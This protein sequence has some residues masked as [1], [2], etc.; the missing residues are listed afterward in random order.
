[1]RPLRKQA[2]SSSE[3]A[4]LESISSTINKYQ[5]IVNGDRVLVGL[6]GGPDSVALLT[7]LQALS[8]NMRFSLSAVYINHQ[9][10]PK[11]HLAEEKFCRNL[12][13]KL[14]IP[15]YVDRY[16][17][18]LIARQ[19][20]IGVEEAGREIRYAVFD[21]LCK[22]R[23]FTKVALGHQRDDNV[24]T[25]L[26][27]I[28]RGTGLSG[29]RGIPPCRGKIIRPLLETSRV[30]ILGWLKR[31]RLRYRIDS[32]NPNNDYTR[33]V[34]RNQILP[35]LRTKLNPSVNSAI[36]RLAIA[37]EE[38][39]AFCDKA[40]LKGIKQAVSRSRGGKII[41][42]LKRWG[43]YD[44]FVRRRL[45]RYCLTELSPQM[46]A[47]DRDVVDRL[48]R[49]VNGIHVRCSMPEGITCERAGTCLYFYRGAGLLKQTALPMPGSVEIVGMGASVVLR[50]RKMAGAKKSRRSQAV[51]LDAD[52]L[53]GAL[54]VRPIRAGDRFAPLGMTGTKKIGDYFTDKKVDRPLRDETPVVCDTRG[55]VWLVGY[56]ISDRVK[57]D[58]ATRKVVEIAVRRKQDSPSAVRAFARP[59]ID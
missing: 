40:I 56:E 8:K 6:S 2:I 33:N 20:K 38:S 30:D 58:A 17:V 45:L 1:V 50:V 41:L 48:D 28:M 49:F 42:D 15:L 51:F 12:C 23:G 3:T 9:L 18:P 29:L 4:M 24:E 53:E 54:V 27:R 34:I 25:I 7:I 39:E 11:E 35:I 47:P 31:H 44:S 13:A 14:V 59:E 21:Q 52:K 16:D 10:R 5:M 22:K 37:A 46:H 55:I 19:K 57:R 36:L 32:S 43:T 26:F